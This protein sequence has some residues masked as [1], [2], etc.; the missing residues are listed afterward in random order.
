MTQATEVS[1]P[2]RYHYFRAAGSPVGRMLKSRLERHARSPLDISDE[3]AERP[4]W[5]A[6]LCRTV[7]CITKTPEPISPSLAGPQFLDRPIVPKSK[8]TSWTLTAITV[9]M[10]RP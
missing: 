6:P 2:E 4:A 10:L 8:I 9:W 7:V 1:I 5:I 3:L